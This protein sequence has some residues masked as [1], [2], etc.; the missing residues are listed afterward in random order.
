M[1]ELNVTETQLRSWRLRQ[2]AAGLKQ[3]ILA[4]EVATPTVAWRWAY[5]APTMACALLTLM[6]LRHGGDGLGSKPMMAMVLSNQSCAAYAMDETQTAQNHLASVSFDSTN[7]G[8]FRSITRF[9]P[10]TNFSN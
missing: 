10:T 7:Y 2:P 3:K 9:T 5:L 1:K 8:G 4:T 6:A